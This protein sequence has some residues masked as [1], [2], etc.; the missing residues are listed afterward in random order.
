MHAQTELNGSQWLPHGMYKK[1]RT[2]FKYLHPKYFLYFLSAAIQQA[3]KLCD[4]H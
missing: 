1:G 3:A 2:F 4:N